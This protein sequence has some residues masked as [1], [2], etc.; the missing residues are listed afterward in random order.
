MWWRQAK[1]PS[2]LDKARERMAN[3]DKTYGLPTGMFCADELLCELN[4]AR[5]PSR[6]T[7]LC[8]VVEAMFSYETMFSVSGD[9]AFADRVERIAFNALPVRS[10]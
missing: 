5:M 4:E 3:M 1:D 8:T 9:V 7:E 6:G 10:L 2:L